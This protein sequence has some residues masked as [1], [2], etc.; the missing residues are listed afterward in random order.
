MRSIGILF[1]WIVYSAGHCAG[2]YSW[3]DEAGVRHFGDRPPVENDARH[4]SLP[5]VP[6]VGT[7]TPKAL[8]KAAPRARPPA[9]A[10]TA[11][12]DAPA[13]ERKR[14]EQCHKA[15]VR[16]DEIR[17]IRRAGYRASES[18]RLDRRERRVRANIRFY[19][20]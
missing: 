4:R 12:S 9:R 19:C 3:V 7:V 1:L 15:R 17:D 10:R 13:A 16:L 2:V 18:R 6:P 20:R 5:E 14:E 11:A 8:P